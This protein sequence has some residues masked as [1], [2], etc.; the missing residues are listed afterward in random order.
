M[1][2]R[3][4]CIGV[5]ATMEDLEHLTTDFSKHYGPGPHPGTGSSQDIH[6]EGGGGV[7]TMERLP[8]MEDVPVERMT[9]KEEFPTATYFDSDGKPL[10]HFEE[11]AMVV[12]QGVKSEVEVYG[13]DLLEEDVLIALRAFRDFESRYPGF[14]PSGVEIAFQPFGPADGTPAN[15]WVEPVGN[16]AHIVQVN[17]PLWEDEPIV[18]DYPPNVM[19]GIRAMHEEGY[20]FDRYRQLIIFHELAHVGGAN[21]GWVPEFGWPTDL[22]YYGPAWYPEQVLGKDPSLPSMYATEHPAEFFAEA[23]ADVYIRGDEAAPLSGRTHR[24]LVRHLVE[25]RVAEIR[26]LGDVDPRIPAREL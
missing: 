3:P 15:A 24:W 14:L 6:G 25:N 2:D 23:L 10:D 26:A 20:D 16:A 17:G 1:A 7:G 8:G 12:W 13:N 5:P 21:Q 19:T 4:L 22:P 11:N 9:L 18:D